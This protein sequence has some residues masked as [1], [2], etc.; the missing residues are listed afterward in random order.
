VLVDAKRVLQ[1]YR[2]A[3]ILNGLIA[4]TCRLPMV[5]I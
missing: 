3:L 2:P 1:Q 4:A 5:V